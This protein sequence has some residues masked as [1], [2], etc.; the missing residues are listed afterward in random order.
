MVMFWGGILKHFRAVFW[1]SWGHFG[2]LQWPFGGYFD[3]NGCLGPSQLL[4]QH[5]GVHWGISGQYFMMIF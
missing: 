3:G 4:G 2:M 5:F 1:G